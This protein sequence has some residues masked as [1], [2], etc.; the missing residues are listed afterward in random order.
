[1]EQWIDRHC[2]KD[3]QGQVWRAARRFALFAAAGEFATTY[4][5]TGWP[6]GEALAAGAEGFRDWLGIRGGTEPAEV[7]RGIDQVRA[8]IARHG[9][10]RF[11]DWNQPD[12]TVRD[13]AG[14]RRSDGSYLFFPEAFRE[15]CAGLDP[16]LVAKALAER[17]ML[18][19]GSDK[20][21]KVVRLPATKE[22]Q[23]FYVVTSKLITEG[24]DT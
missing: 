10:S 15:A 14:F 16:G 12:D 18:D 24:D 13:R 9:S 8:F 2:P 7:L 1:M 23:R 20:L 22:S 4:G 19:P 17:G 6:D 21:S 5:I 11:A 3:A